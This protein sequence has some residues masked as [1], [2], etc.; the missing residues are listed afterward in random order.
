MNA[1]AASAVSRLE[2]LIG[3]A[4]LINDPAQLPGYAIAGLTPAAAVR[5]DTA[6]EVAEV[7]RF[8]GVENLAIVPCG[9]RTKLGM[10][11][12]PHRYDIALDLSGLNRVTA[13]DPADLTVGLEPGVTLASLARTLGQHGQF[14]PLGAPFTS[15]ATVGGT[16]VSG[17]DGPLRQGYGTARDFLLG[18]EFVTGDGVAVKSGG[19]VVKNVAGFDL[20][21]PLI[22]SLGTLA[23]VTEINFRTFP[24]PQAMRGF[25][26][27]FATADGAAALRHAIARSFLRP[28]TL[29]ILSAGACDLFNGAAASRIEPNALPSGLLSPSG[30]FAGWILATSFA[31]DEAVLARCE[32]DLRQLA[33]SSGSTTFDVFGAGPDRSVLA[34][35]F[36]RLREFVPIALESSPATTVVKLSASPAHL[37]HA[38]CSV[39][40]SAEEHSLPWACIARG[41]GVVYAALL[42]PERNDHALHRV[43]AATKRMAADVAALGGHCVIPWCPA[44]RSEL[45]IWGSSGNVGLMQKLKTVF[46]PHA[47]L[48]PGRFVGGI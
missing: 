6:E 25:L 1:S 45:S 10:G 8:A 13:Y 24:A 18:M 21:K 29:E 15:R 26:V 2:G 17:V 16:V 34:A 12:P 36:G 4:G 35:V 33:D 47:I 46:D 37:E 27:R 11:S 5:P 41:I 7:L 40:H 3:A 28:L 32:R 39:K 38:L 30:A 14:L 44:G 20:H 19:R 42:P 22:G 23:V 9:A 31:G 43:A 48:S